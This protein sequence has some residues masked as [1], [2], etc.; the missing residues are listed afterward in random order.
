MIEQSTFQAARLKSI[1]LRPQWEKP[2]DSSSV[3]TIYQ[4]HGHTHLLA[5]SK[6]GF[7]V[8]LS[9]EKVEQPNSAS[10][11]RWSWKLVATT[12]RSRVAAHAADRSKVGPVRTVCS[13]LIERVPMS[14]CTKG[15]CGCLLPADLRTA[16]SP[17]IV[18]PTKKTT[19]LLFLI[20][21]LC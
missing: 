13:W 6:H 5:E 9:D 2:N 11:N 15:L 21:L 7:A 10:W 3:L 19:F 8:W 18:S 12:C 1:L 17:H 4:L 16:G 20:L 14:E